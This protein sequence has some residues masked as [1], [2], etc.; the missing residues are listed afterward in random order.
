MQSD[1]GVAEGRNHDF[2]PFIF[3]FVVVSC[4]HIAQFLIYS[5]PTVCAQL[6]GNK[7]GE[8]MG[9]CGMVEKVLE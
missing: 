9:Q 3:F 4:Q 7:K 8:R 2:F 6:L 1:P 5:T